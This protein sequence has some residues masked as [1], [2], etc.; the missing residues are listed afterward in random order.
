[1]TPP[2]VVA[3]QPRTACVEPYQDVR[4]C[5]RETMYASGM[6]YWWDNGVADC[7]VSRESGWNRWAVSPTSDYGLWQI[8]K[9]N[10]WLFEG[11][12]WADPKANTLV[13]IELYRRAGNSW[14]PWS[15]HWMCGV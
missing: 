7:I 5:V 13:A 12:S 3:P 8:N 6:A 10:H 15:V 2:V 14:S 4:G 9:V 11:A 1:M